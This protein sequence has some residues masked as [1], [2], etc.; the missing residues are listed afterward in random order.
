[1]QFH[2][3]ANQS[4]F[5]INGFALGL[6]LKQRHKKTRKWPTRIDRF[7]LINLRWLPTVLTESTP[8]KG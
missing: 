7:V 5:H 3:H 1:M 6:V 8:E 4:H 2:F